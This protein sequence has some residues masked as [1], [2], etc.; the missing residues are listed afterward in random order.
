MIASEEIPDPGRRK[1]Q[2]FD[3]VGSVDV[4]TPQVTALIDTCNQQLARNPK[5]GWVCFLPWESSRHAEGLD[6]AR[7][8]TCRM[9]PWMLTYF[10]LPP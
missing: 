6:Q 5:N 7:E 4:M 3:G 9:Q 2:A 10:V 8:N 1:R